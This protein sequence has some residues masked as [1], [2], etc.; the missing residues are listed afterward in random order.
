MDEPLFY[1]TTSQRAYDFSGNVLRE[2]RFYKGKI[3]E[4]ARDS[5]RQVQFE[6]SL[7]DE[8]L[9]MDKVAGVEDMDEVHIHPFSWG[10]AKKF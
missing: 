8:K 4:Q 7:K 5:D 1:Q 2:N 10:Y 3:S 9:F 6:E